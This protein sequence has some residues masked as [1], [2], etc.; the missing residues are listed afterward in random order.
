[1]RPGVIAY[2]VALGHGSLGEGVPFG[3]NDLPPHYEERRFYGMLRERVEDARRDF[4]LRPIV[5]GKSN[6]H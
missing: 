3:S 4:R 2:P 6:H 5:E 1:M